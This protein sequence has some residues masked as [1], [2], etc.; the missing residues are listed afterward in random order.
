MIVADIDALED[1]GRWTPICGG[2]RSSECL[3]VALHLK[4]N[5]KDPKDLYRL[6]QQIE[7]WQKRLKVHNAQPD[8]VFTY[9]VETGTKIS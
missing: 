6:D 1:A 9:D 2:T 3:V 7:V 5:T 4:K 8:R